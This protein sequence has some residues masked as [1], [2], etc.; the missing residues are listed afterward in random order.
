MDSKT[1]QKTLELFI[2]D[3]RS[4]FGQ[5]FSEKDIRNR[6]ENYVKTL[7]R[8]MP[9]L[10]EAPTSLPVGVPY[11]AE[12]SKPSFG[13]FLDDILSTIGLK[14]NKPDTKTEW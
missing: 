13:G 4:Q 7:E 9:E 11:E 2:R 3:L 12:K 8:H 10:N 1:R 6:A 14:K 5:D